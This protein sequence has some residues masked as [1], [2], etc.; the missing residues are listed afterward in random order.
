VT[1][2]APGGD[3]ADPHEAALQRQLASDWGYRTDKDD[4]VE[5][6]LLDWD[7]WKR[8][9]FWGVQHFVGFRYGKDHHAVA[10]VLV[11]DAPQGET[12]DSRSCL[13]RF[14]VWARPQL[15]AFDLKLGSGSERKAVWQKQPI[16]VRSVDGQVSVGFS[17][18]GF[19]A[20]W[21]AYPAYPDACLVYAMAAPWDTRPE[22]ARR[23]RDR[24]ASEGFERLVA[25]TPGRPY[26][27]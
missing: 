15:A 4:Q 26:R 19:S 8:V 22:L 2:A 10:I 7:H 3:A 25:L 23:L 24:W 5:I 27:K 17:T 1:V 20:A 6:P 13:R 11:Q 21:T 18:R 16:Y 9:R 14:E 12:V